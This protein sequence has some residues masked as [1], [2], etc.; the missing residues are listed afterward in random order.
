MPLY[1]IEDPSSGR[2]V[3]IEGDREPTQDDAAQIFSSLPSSPEPSFGQEVSSALQRGVSGAQERMLTGLRL[4]SGEEA[5]PM[6]TRQ[7]FVAAM[8][9]PRYIEGLSD[10][11]QRDYDRRLIG[12]PSDQG[13]GVRAIE[14]GLGPAAR[15]SAPENRRRIYEETI[16]DVV[17]ERQNIPAPGSAVRQ[18]QEGDWWEAFKSSPLRV[19]TSV[20]A[21]SLPQ[22]VPTLAAAVATRGAVGP[23][24]LG[25]V[26][27]AAGAGGGSFATEALS[28]FSETAAESGYDFKDPAQVREFFAN[29]EKIQEAKDRG[30]RRGVP[31]AA[32]DAVSMGVAG[33]LFGAAKTPLSRAAATG[34]EF[35]LQPALGAG[36]EAL[37]QVSDK[38]RITS[39]RDIFAEALGEVVP[40]ALEV[41]ANA[42]L[43]ALSK[44]PSSQRTTEDIPASDATALTAP[45]QPVSAPTPEAAPPD[46]LGAATTELESLED[47]DAVQEP[48]PEAGVLGAEVQEPAIDVGLPEVGEG[49]AVQTGPVDQTQEGQG[50]PE[51]G[52]PTVSSLVQAASTP[53]E[54]LDVFSSRG[55]S[56]TTEA[57]NLGGSITTPEQLSEIQGLQQ[58]A[59][60]DFRKAIAS[61]EFDTA[62]M[63]ASKS[64]FYREAEEWATGTGS[65]GEHQ[66]RTDP[67]YQPPM[68]NAAEREKLVARQ[69]DRVETTL[70]GWIDQLGKSPGTLSDP[71]LLQAGIK[72]VAQIAVRV[73][74]A[75]YRT[76]KDVVAAINAGLEEFRKSG[77][78]FKEQEARD[79][80]SK[81][82][83]EGPPGMSFTGPELN[84]D[85]V[86]SSRSALARYEYI[87]QAPPGQANA[88]QIAYANDLADFYGDDFD[89][90]IA[91]MDRT[92]PPSFQAVI[93][94]TLLA[95]VT[96]KAGKPGTIQFMEMTPYIRRLTAGA[97]ANKTDT[98]QALQAEGVVN[99]ILDPY[100]PLYSWMELLE[101]RQEEVVNEKMGPDAV[102]EIRDTMTDSGETA[103]ETVP[104]SI[105]DEEAAELALIKRVLIPSGTV[106]ED[107]PPDIAQRI[108]DSLGKLG[109]WRERFTNLGTQKMADDFAELVGIKKPDPKQAANVGSFERLVRRELGRIIKESLRKAGLK[110]P[111]SD[112]PNVA[113][114][115][116]QFIGNDPLRSDKV[117]V[118]DQLVRE[119]IE[120]SGLPALQQL[121]DF[122]G[123]F[124]T[125]NAPSETLV[126]RLM[127]Q[128]MKDVSFDLDQFA[129]QDYVDRGRVEVLNNFMAK[130]GAELIPG[131]TSGLDVDQ[132]AQVAGQIYDSIIEKRRN[133][134]EMSIVYRRAKEAMRQTAKPE[135]EAQAIINQFA[136]T[137]TDTPT[138]TKKQQSEIRKIFSEYMAGTETSEGFQ[139]RMAAQGL[140][141]GI[142]SRMLSV[143]DRELQIR[144][145]ADLFKAQEKFNDWLSSE[146]NV[147][148]LL[149]AGASKL[150]LNW[151]DLFRDLPEKQ[152]ERRAAIM[153]K[154]MSDP[155][156][157]GLSEASRN[158]LVSALDQAWDRQRQEYFRR[159]FSKIVSLPKIDAETRKQAE[160]SIPE[161]FRMANQGLLDNESFRNALAARMG[162]E[163]IDGPTAKKLA[164]IG[165][166]A[167]RAPDGVIRNKFLGE[168]QRAIEDSTSI[169]PYDLAKSFWYANVLSGTGTWATIF[170][171]SGMFGAV[172]TMLAGIDAATAMKRPDVALK[173]IGDFFT[174]VPEGF[175]NFWDV[176]STGDYTRFPEFR[177]MFSESVSSRLGPSGPTSEGRFKSNELER[178]LR[179]DNPA[180]KAIGTL[181]F[182]QR[183]T[184]GLDQAFSVG[185]RNSGAFYA[186]LSRK[187]A[188]SLGA[189]MSKSDREKTKAATEQA[190]KEFKDS[191][192]QNPKGVDVAMRR[193]EILEQ[194]VSDEVKEAAVELGREAN[195]NA[196][197]KGIG[198]AFYNFLAPAS[199]IVKVPLGITFLRAAINLIQNGANWLPTGMVNYARSAPAVRSALEKSGLGKK[200]IDALSPDLAPEQRR[201]VALKSLAGMAVAITFGSRFLGK[202]HDDDEW[203]IA[204]SGFGLT[205]GQLK[206]RTQAGIRPNSFWKIDPATGK[207]MVREFSQTPFAAPLTVIGNIRDAELYSGNEWSDQTNLEKVMDATLMGMTYIT[208][209]P[210][211]SQAS[212]MLGATSEARS[213]TE[214]AE[215]SDKAW[216]RLQRVGGAYASGAV[217][218][219]SLLKDIDVLSDPSVYNPNGIQTGAGY[220]LRNLP[221]ARRLSATEPELNILGEPI[222]Q[223]RS[224]LSRFMREQDNSP[225]MNLLA[226]KMSEGVF[227]SWPGRTSLIVDSAGVRRQM[228]EPEWRRF[229]KVHGQLFKR[230]LSLDMEDIKARPS[231]AELE[232][233]IQERLQGRMEGLAP[234]DRTELDAEIRSFINTESADAVLSKASSDI[235]SL[236]REQMG[237][238][239]LDE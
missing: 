76:G 200:W 80:L 170:A 40:G 62:A 157:E 190:M 66:L 198:G 218:V 179:S 8:E 236:V 20:A 172:N 50:I 125:R 212:G 135:Q 159:E 63:L 220:F 38:G 192:I 109:N 154:A 239:P 183:I 168:A 207:M 97:K 7:Q 27:G 103:S 208:D 114:Q 165:E 202:D 42:G 134:N 55:S 137:Q 3:T 110:L 162:V 182:V 188:E 194:G 44:I 71:F 147:G 233:R 111:V 23:G 41:G 120:E 79:W 226:Q 193:R 237:F 73:A 96:Q 206:A 64:Q 102:S 195:L 31:I 90:A 223:V 151:R 129:N 161:L 127:V 232:R 72:P 222:Q 160:D 234:E 5:G 191:G 169:N 187:D 34:A 213:R 83:Q 201:L 94:A 140:G 171:G 228:T 84:R 142:I 189:L 177:R 61:G 70:E 26:A 122:V 54:L 17:S 163:A 229:T 95:R 145:A 143:A 33:T 69:K 99:R 211:L 215:L 35:L 141:E 82:V 117:E 205:P 136:T 6:P 184:T 24:V 155:R 152:S 197:P 93:R 105:V 1:E 107:V 45:E 91:E 81:V 58:Q 123:G 67:N 130:L 175:Q 87:R 15:F 4:A 98:A 148:R 100:V 101:Q 53:Q 132:L 32:L 180:K 49:D 68:L 186:A 119:R 210:V 21:E 235:G 238:G 204:G 149:R 78:Q 112:K 230:F 164:E 28:A 118:L 59:K 225:E 75:A 214:P 144:R 37:A 156:F 167:Q 153:E 77:V 57:Y 39:G 158:A 14:S 30:V 178:M 217:P 181:A 25:R 216:E 11:A 92:T 115:I 174:S 203:E 196:Q 124:L 121:W 36:G 173:I 65:A 116:A 150:D 131:Q 166:K 9:D 52:E 74:L 139:T 221:F 19:A 13:A 86:G 22:S 48:S 16:S 231:K 227:P 10:A 176:L 199:M 146:K 224:P 126:R 138:W 60:A 133:A 12:L 85:F 104:E 209:L 106:P 56:L 88:E 219:S 89:S 108:M 47:Q 51:V 128:S 2:I 113:A 185:V 46:D 29:R 18:F 43:D